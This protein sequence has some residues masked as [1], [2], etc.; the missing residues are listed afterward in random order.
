M[1][2]P[3]QELEDL[4]RLLA[5]VRGLGEAAP[6]RRAPPEAPKRRRGGLLDLLAVVAAVYTLVVATPVGGLVVRGVHWATG[7]RARTR[8]LVTYFKTERGAGV[9]SRAVEA[10]ASKPAAEASTTPGARQAG[11]DPELA[12]ALALMLSGGRRVDGHFDVR[13]PPGT[14]AS[15][16]ALGEVA[17]PA[18]APAGVREAALLA[19]LGRLQ[20][21]LQSPEAAVAALAVEL[22]RVRYAVHLARAAR[23]AEPER[24]EGFR[25][26][27]PPDDRAEADPVV[28]GTFALV[29]AFGM[30]WPVPTTARITSPFGWRVHPVLGRR[31]LHGGVDVAVPTGTDVVAIADAEVL[32]VATDGVN[33]RYVKLDHGHG[34]TSVYCHNDSTLVRRG[35]RVKQGEVVAKS[36]ASG[37]VTGPH[38]HFQ[39]ELDETPVDPEIFLR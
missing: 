5:E 14:A 25:P 19:G 39:V 37:R 27:L 38:L 2:E 17:P 4:G 7:Q 18:T 6:P 32:Y 12:R 15:F 9:D 16:A 1:T 22:P 31:R 21:D 34:L 33:G 23:V 26:Y 3:K 11:V 24:Y 30:R 35:Q 28:H 36:G 8:P 20:A 29:T 10:V 13:Y